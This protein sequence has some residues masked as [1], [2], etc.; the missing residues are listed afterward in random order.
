MLSLSSGPQGWALRALDHVTKSGK[1][2]VYMAFNLPVEYSV[3]FY[4]D[5]LYKLIK[6]KSPRGV[7]L[8]KDREEASVSEQKL[9]PA[10]S[11]ARSVIYQLCVCNDWQYF[12]TGTLNPEWHDRS[13]LFHFRSAFTQFIRDL[14]KQPGYENLS[15]VLIPEK[16][17]DGSW[18][19]HG[20][21]RGLPE[22]ALTPF[23]RGIHPKKLVD[24][25]YL[26]WGAYAKKFGFCSL[27]HI[28]D[29]DAVAGYLTKYI[30]KD[31]AA[32]VVDVGGHTYFCT[33]GLRRALSYGH[34]YGSDIA[35]DSFLTYEGR[36]CSTGYVKDVP[37]HFWLDYMDVSQMD[38][39]SV[40]DPVVEDIL[41]S[42]EFEQLVLAG[43]P[44]AG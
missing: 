16:H 20:L 40:D 31:L 5:G 29:L 35:L 32:S 24:G 26:N 11:R 10:F 3:K 25:G 1:G 36:F 37:W 2:L 4:R 39:F 43:F 18:H 15:Y 13:N 22:S 23:V 38:I 6:F 34:I 8:G 21:L 17:K 41:E 33:R 12:F 27:D 44:S 42:P 30:S 9:D 28:N 7:S 19:M 14:R